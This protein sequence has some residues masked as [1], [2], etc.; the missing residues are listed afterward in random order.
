MQKTAPGVPNGLLHQ[1]DVECVGPGCVAA[2]PDID[3]HC[4]FVN[5]ADGSDQCLP[6]AELGV[7]HA[8]RADL[9][10]YAV[11]A[12]Y[13]GAE[14]VLLS[15][16]HRNLL[17]ENYGCSAVGADPL[18]PLAVHGRHRHRRRGCAAGA[19]QRPTGG[20][21]VRAGVLERTVSDQVFT[22]HVA[23][24]AWIMAMM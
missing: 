4:G 14:E 16:L 12:A 5:G 8:Q 22:G 9:D 11:V 23:L 10:D 2:E 13:P 21:T 24:T 20:E 6:L 17:G 3:G 19:C 15:W 7:G 18:A 1:V